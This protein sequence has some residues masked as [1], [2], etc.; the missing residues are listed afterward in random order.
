[1]DIKYYDFNTPFGKMFLFF[2]SKGIVSISLPNEKEEDVF[3]YINKKYGSTEKVESNQ[4]EFHEQIIQY[5]KGNLKYFSLNLDLQGTEFQKKV[6]A[7][8]LNIPYGETRTYK[9]IAQYIGSPKG[10]RAVGR[11][12]NTNPIPIIVPCHRVI[13]S[14][15]QLVGFAGGLGLKEKLLELEKTM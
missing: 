12:L 3:N 1:M 4:Y 13:G 8:L 9:D 15:G 14:N 11:A 7:E 5:F 2:S 6:W 10:Y